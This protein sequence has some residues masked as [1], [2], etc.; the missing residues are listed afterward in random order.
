MRIV[1]KNLP[2]K[3]KKDEIEAFF[4]SR[5]DVSD[6]Y[7]L[8][9]S[10]GKF[11]R[12]CFVGYKTSEQARDAAA[13][14]NNA[15]FKNHK[16][17]TELA[18]DEQ[19]EEPKNES[20]CRKVLYSKTIVIKNLN[21]KVNEANLE[22]E[23]KKYGKFSEL[24]INR[25]KE[26]TFAVVKFIDGAGATEALKKLKVLSGMRVWTGPYK[27]TAETKTSYYNS[28][29]FNFEAVIKRTCEKKGVDK[30]ILVN[31]DDKDLGT[32]VALL[33]TE[34]VAQTKEFLRKNSLDISRISQEKSKDTIILRNADLLGAIDMVKGKYAMDI[35]PSKCL[36][37]LHFS[38]PED[39]QRCY[40]ELNM[41]RFKNQVIYC[42][43]APEKSTELVEKRAAEEADEPAKRVK[44]TTKVI[45]KNVPFQATEKDLENIFST[46][47]KLLSVRLPK[48]DDKQH[49]G[50]AFVMFD[51]SETAQ[52][53]I[54]HF[55]TSTHLYGR[56]LVIEQAKQ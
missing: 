23:L 19:K 54:E 48:K 3:A 18:V 38:E 52:R 29:F 1:A 43:F 31:I 5:G 27:E 56:R 44:K 6:V 26:K 4:S 40:K 21:E 39:A 17:S 24:K 50:F 36:A 7:M 35:A 28:L 15:M 13:Y 49:R 10:K 55:G 46:G 9:N 16:I 45:V 14:F 34:L 30:R 33:E 12:I 20:E 8:E 11:R 32:R 51:S 22:E 42:E 47:F 2:E 53:A 25:E 41:R 37:L